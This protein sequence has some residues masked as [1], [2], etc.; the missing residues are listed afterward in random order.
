MS[1]SRCIISQSIKDIEPKLMAQT[2]LEFNQTHQLEP[3]QAE[4][5]NKA[6]RRDAHSGS[7]P[8]N[9]LPTREER[10]T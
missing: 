7:S 1:V 5:A 8:D 6:S 3:R 10:K 4:D 2:R 9:Y